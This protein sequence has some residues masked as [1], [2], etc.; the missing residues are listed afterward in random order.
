MMKLFAGVLLALMVAPV[1][2]SHGAKRKTASPDAARKPAR[3]VS[4][5]RFPTG[6][7]L[8]RVIN[9]HGPQMTFEYRG[10]SWCSFTDSISEEGAHGRYRLK[11]VK[12]VGYLRHQRSEATRKMICDYKIVPGKGGRTLTITLQ[13]Q[14]IR[15]GQKPELWS[16]TYGFDR[17]R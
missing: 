5:A 7:W 17:V 10:G 3:R 6:K 4:R 11:I 9:P 13:Q 14:T 16:T 12:S 8:G 2:V 1:A 15:R